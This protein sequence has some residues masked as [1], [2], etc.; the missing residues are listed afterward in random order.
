MRLRTGNVYV[1]QCK[2]V[3]CLLSGRFDWWHWLRMPRMWNVLTAGSVVSFLL[4]LACP[5]SQPSF[6]RRWLTI[7]VQCLFYWTETQQKVFPHSLFNH[8]TMCLATL[9]RHPLFIFGWT[10]VSVP[11][12][13]F[14]LQSSFDSLRGVMNANIQWPLRDH[15]NMNCMRM[16]LWFLVGLLGKFALGKNY[17]KYLKYLVNRI[18]HPV[19]KPC[20]WCFCSETNAKGGKEKELI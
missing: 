14:F 4:E 9:M 3:K 15:S 8:C 10:C 20:H 17:Q 7:F 5:P 6:K 1:C 16:E 19:I 18:M 11:C 12:I 2:P 13:W